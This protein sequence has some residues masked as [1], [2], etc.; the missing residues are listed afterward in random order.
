MAH[1]LASSVRELDPPRQYPAGR[2]WLRAEVADG[3]SV[4]R[5]RSGSTH[6]FTGNAVTIH[7]S[8]STIPPS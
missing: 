5:I 1:H 4:G 3:I 2:V 8:R 7:D 6:T